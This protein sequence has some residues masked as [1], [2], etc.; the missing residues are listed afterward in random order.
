MLRY[1]ALACLAL[2]PGCDDTRAG[3]TQSET[4]AAPRQASIEVVDQPDTSAA[5]RR[6]ES[7]AAE[8][9][10]FLYGDA[11]FEVLNLAD[12]VEL[13]VVPEGGGQRARVPRAQLRDRYEWRVGTGASQ[14]SFV[15][16][17]VLTKMTTR[18]GMH[19][20]CRAQQLASRVPALANRPHVGV[21]LEPPDMQSCLETWNATFV[22]DTGGTRP[23]LIA[24]VYDQWEW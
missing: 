10:S 6:L 9:V 7:A 3:S 4:A 13:L 18:A 22:F 1:A 16:T 8:V 14:R 12:T 19:M 5:A 17:G 11:D 20:N 2:L 15:P 23:R 24:A 21:R